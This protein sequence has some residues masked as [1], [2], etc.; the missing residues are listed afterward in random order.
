MRYGPV[1]ALSGVSFEVKQGEIVAL[2]GPN[3]AGK[4]TTMKILTT[5]QHPT[6]GTAKINEF[7][8]LENPLEARAQI[9]YLP[10]STFS[11]ESAT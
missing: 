11:G 10:E 2:L 5:Y 4:S 8:V 7:D 1:T 3:G 6:S 9:G